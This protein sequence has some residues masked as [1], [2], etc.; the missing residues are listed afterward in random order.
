MGRWLAAVVVLAVLAVV[1]AWLVLRIP[2]QVRRGSAAAIH[3]GG[4]GR[5][6]IHTRALAAM[7]YAETARLMSAG[8]GK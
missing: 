5:Q 6:V 3:A 8:L 2:R 4:S 1:A 7:R